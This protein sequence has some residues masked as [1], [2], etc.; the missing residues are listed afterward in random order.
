MKRKTPRKTSQSTVTVEEKSSPRAVPLAPQ[1]APQPAP[2]P[3]P[4]EP[5]VRVSDLD[6]LLA[7]GL[8]QR[9]AVLLLSPRCEERD[10]LLRKII[11]SAISAGMPT[12]YLSSDPTKI[13]DM[14]STYK[15]NFYIVSPQAAIVSA[16]PANVYK[17]PSI[18]SLSDL[19]AA[20]ARIMQIHSQPTSLNR[21][22]VVDL[23]TYSHMFLLHQG[24]TARK[25][26]SDFLAKRKAQSFTVLAFLNP[27]VTSHEETQTLSDVF[28]GL[29]E[30]YQKQIHGRSPR[31]LTIRRMFGRKYSDSDVMLDKNKLF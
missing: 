30:I 15:E 25:W 20:F 27:L 22:L 31:F 11:R 18:D 28:D 5:P 3:A 9:A 1:T 13:Q 12:V 10:L 17:V 19:D 21:L 26:F 29:M 14:A 24:V 7:A 8:P 4:R 16:P 23:L 2:Q 6:R